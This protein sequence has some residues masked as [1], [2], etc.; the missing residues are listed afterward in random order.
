M[1]REEKI[2]N[3]APQNLDS[4]K[5]Y[6]KAEKQAAAN[7]ES[8]ENKKQDI[9]G[10]NITDKENSKAVKGDQSNKDE[11]ESNLEAVLPQTEELGDTQKTENNE[12]KD[13]KTPGKRRIIKKIIYVV[14]IFAISLMIAVF[15]LYCISDFLGISRPECSAD[16]KIPEHAK[17]EQIAS[18]LQKNGIIR[19]ALLFR[20]YIYFSKAHNLQY[21]TYTLNSQMSYGYIAAKLKNPANS[22]STVKVTI[23]EGYTLQRIGDL[24][25]KDN[26]CTKQDFLNSASSSRISFDFSSQIPNDD[27][28]FYKL[29]G[30]LFPDTYE[31]FLHQSSDAVVKKMLS[32]FDTRYNTELRSATKQSGMTVDQ[33]VTLASIIQTEASKTSEMGKVSSVFHNR[34]ANGVNGKKLLQSD[35]TVLYVLRVIKPVLTST[36]T[37]FSSDYNTYKKEGLPPGAIC[38]PGVAAIK[39]AL[40]P[41]STPYYYFVSDKSGKYYYAETYTQHLVNVKNAVATG[42]AIGT[43]VVN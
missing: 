25:Q 14:C 20:A 13:N 5:T 43:N 33:V 22:R 30:Y 3:S 39:A 28:R 27:K 38:N 31:F 41:E 17:T 35:A 15:A 8:V 32:D 1:E 4:T 42:K 37:E 9:T 16:V 34:L 6:E 12:I 2:K 18:I 23:P 7:T 21:G 36:D 10:S 19:S 26:V 24:L 40:S 11:K 29:E